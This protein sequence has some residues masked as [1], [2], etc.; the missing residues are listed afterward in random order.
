[1]PACQDDPHVALRVS[2]G[3]LIGM[4]FGLGWTWAG[5]AGVSRLKAGLAVMAIGVAL[6]ALAIALGG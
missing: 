3:V 6:V 4:L 2:N 5:Y 1:V